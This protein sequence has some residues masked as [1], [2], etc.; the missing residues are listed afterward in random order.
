MYANRRSTL[1]QIL[2]LLWVSFVFVTYSAVPSAHEPQETSTDSILFLK[3]SAFQAAKDENSE[4]AVAYIDAYIK[5]TLDLE[6]V[7]HS[8]FSSLR[9]S[10]DFKLLEKTYLPKIQW[11]SVIYIYAGLIGFFIVIMFNVQKDKD[12]IATV[13][14]SVLIFI[15]SYFIIHVGL[16]SM[17]Y[18]LYI[19]HLYST[20]TIFSFLYGPLMY[21]YFKRIKTGHLF[22]RKD[23]LHLLPTVILIALF[24]PIFILPEDEKLRIMLGVGKYKDRAYGLEISVGKMI[25]LLVYTYFTVRLFLKTRKDVHAPEYVPVYR[26]QR[27]IVLFQVG[28]TLTYAIYLVLLISYVLTGPMF[29]MQLIILSALVLYVAYIAYVNPKTLLGYQLEASFLKYKNSGL[30]TSYS[31]ELKADMMALLEKEKLYRNNNINLNTMAE[32]LGTTRHNTSQIINEH[33]GLTFFELI[34]EFRIKDAMEIL[35]NDASG[36]KNIID[37]A[38]EVGYNNKVTFNKSFKK[39]NDITPSQYVKSLRKDTQQTTSED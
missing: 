6:F 11:G 37:V 9:G 13:L 30:T 15:H 22:K 16:H 18:N 21:F 1:C 23:L 14:L 39:I 26:W 2:L 28:F 32:R 29:H 4:T 19:P 5:K 33:F 10:Q 31:E 25:S 27:N 35:K 20:S 34:N 24:S 8:S 17:N 38:Y 36:K 3:E 12:R 7:E